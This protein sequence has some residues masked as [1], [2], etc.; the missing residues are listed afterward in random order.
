MVCKNQKGQ[1]AVEYIL[2]FAMVSFIVLTIFQSKVIQDFMSE[3]GT[4]IQAMKGDMEFMY[5]HALPGRD[6][7]GQGQN[8]INYSANTNPSYHDGQSTRF[9]GP[10]EKYSN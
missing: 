3:D 1:S 2:L 8:Q 10:I 9:F 6:Q 5:R 7:L 4:F